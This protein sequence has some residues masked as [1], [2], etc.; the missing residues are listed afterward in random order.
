MSESFIFFLGGHDA[1]M[2]EIKSILEQKDI[3]FYD[4]N[5]QWGARLSDYKEELQQLR[6]E[7]KA[8]L[9]ELN[10]DQPLPENSIIIDH[11][12]EKAGS[13]MQTSIEQVAELLG[14]KL[15]R[16]QKLIAANDKAHI[17]GMMKAGATK[18]EIAE[19]RAFDRRCQGVTEKE[20]KE[21]EE[22]CKDFKSNGE[23]DILEIPFQHTSPVTDRLFGQYQNL[24][25]IMPEMINFFG[26][27]RMVQKLG[28][29][30]KGSWYGGNLPEEGFWGIKKISQE[31]IRKIKNYIGRQSD[32][33]NN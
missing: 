30:F 27:G 7:I 14:I 16:R 28:K 6:P 13:E 17:K 29:T 2:C 22:I 5:L 3:P 31:R 8:V 18:E 33:Q 1:E 10:I 24:L 20:E 32:F 19:I 26:D 9:I 15:S 23:L 21:A 12:S 4:K 25:V 11:H